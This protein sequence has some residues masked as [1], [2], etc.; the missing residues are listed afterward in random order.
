MSFESSAFGDFVLIGS[1]G[2]ASYNFAATLDDALM[3][4]TDVIRGDDHLP[5]TPRQ[6]LL[7]EAMGFNLPKFSHLPLVLAPDG[8]PLSKRHS[9]L[10]IRA[11][12]EE[13]FLDSAILNTT[14]KLG[15]S[16]T[17]DGS[18]QL[19]SLQEM[20]ERFAGQDG[21]GDGG[22]P[23][24]SKSSSLFDPN[25]LSAFNRLA[26]ADMGADE[27]LQRIDLN[28]DSETACPKADAIEAVKRNCATLKEVAKLAWPLLYNDIT[29]TDTATAALNEE[30]AASV[31]A[32]FLKGI[33]ESKEE[34]IEPEQYKATV[35]K[36][37]QESGAKGRKLF[38]PIRCA[39][40]G[41]TDGI[42]LE[43]IVQR[44]GKETIIKRLAGA[45]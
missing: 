34:I 37:K 39:L 9:H 15:W 36:V 43:K 27:L 8:S 14:V 11:L 38:L 23:R 7:Y 21:Q 18:A 42:E 13:G 4:I 19:M 35:E 10:S 20:V 28:D 40:T 32:L 30:S 3:H 25:H 45:L 17:T 44:L 26:I 31:L 29:P 22:G 33:E 6:I 1:D 16:P 5:N 2:T 41:R 24:L 12:R